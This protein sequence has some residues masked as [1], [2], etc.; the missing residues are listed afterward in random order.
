M[1]FI[2]TGLSKLGAASAQQLGIAAAAS[3]SVMAVSFS[4]IAYQGYVAEKNREQAHKK[5]VLTAENRFQEVFYNGSNEAAPAVLGENEI[6]GAV[7]TGNTA[8]ERSIPS[9]AENTSSSSASNGKDNSK[10]ESVSPT[11]VETEEGETPG[12]ATE[13]GTEATVLSTETEESTEV[14]TEIVDSKN[15]KAMKKDVQ[16]SVAPAQEASSEIAENASA[17]ANAAKPATDLNTPET[18]AE[19]ASDVNTVGSLP[20]KSDSF[21]QFYGS[22]TFNDYNVFLDTAMGP[23]TYYNQHDSHWAKYLYGGQDSISKYGCGPTTVAMIVS[24]FG[25]V[26]GSI[27]PK[28]MAEWSSHYKFYAPQSGSYHDYI[29]SALSAFDLMVDSVQERTPAK[30]AELLN[31]GHILVALMGKGALTNGGHFVI[32]TKQNPNGTVSIAD[33]NSYKKTQQDWDPAQ[34]MRELKKNYDGGGPLWAVSS[35]RNYGR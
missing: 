5:T 27:T 7:S 31:S 20:V 10:Q 19:S 28:E 30:V 33:P 9:E 6:A 13:K 2:G 4:A 8:V 12:N 26:N 29:P 25:N 18:V 3:L 17:A 21:S 15:K 22:S 24:S 11:E 14:I 32:I 23:M 16:E 35:P 1:G 34:L